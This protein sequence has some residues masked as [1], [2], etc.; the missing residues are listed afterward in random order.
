MKWILSM[1]V[2]TFLG[3]I[4]S[5]AHAAEWFFGASSQ[6]VGVGGLVDVGVFVNSEGE[7]LNA[8]EGRVTY[9]AD[10]LMLKEVRDAGSVVTVW[11]IRSVVGVT[12]AGVG[13][14]SFS[15]IAPGGYSGSTG[16]LFTLIFEAKALGNPSI[17]VVDDRILL[18]N[19]AGTSAAVHVS[20]LTI[21][22][23][24]DIPPSI[25]A[26]EPD[27][28]LPD[29]FTP[30]IN[31]TDSAFDGKWFVTF[32]TH[33]KESGIAGYFVR[34]RLP[35]M[36]VLSWFDDADWKPTTSPYVI[37][38]Q[39]RKC[40]VE[41]KA[42]DVAGNEREGRGQ[43]AYCTVLIPWMRNVFVL[44]GGG[45]LALMLGVFSLKRLW[46]KNGRR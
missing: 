6:R 46:R 30:M 24:P 5:N 25:L 3:F 10:V 18:N 45:I 40:G 20:P 1:I 28:I 29:E 42:V 41:I 44:L 34:E 39:T 26:I 22:V 17:T 31:R 27:T 13:A 36:D 2:V 19:G 38:D 4:P 15:G 32:E 11:M 23:V 21:N 9:P 43:V 14:V 8:F 35:W 33:D 16:K 37:I 12:D 7:S